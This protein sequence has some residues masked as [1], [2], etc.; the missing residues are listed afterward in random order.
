MPFEV[1]MLSVGV[2]DA[3]V[4]RYILPDTG[5]EV[6]ILIDAGNKQDGPRIVD[7]IKAHTKQQY[8]DLAIC[9]HPDADHIGGFPYIVEH[10]RIEEFWIHDPTRHK[11]N[12]KK[13]LEG[14][15]ADKE[16]EKGL[17]YVVE[18]LHHSY[19]LLKAIDSKQI[20]RRE[21]FAGATF[22][23][24]PLTVVGPTV[25]YYESLLGRFRDADLLWEEELLLEKS[26]KGGDPINLS[27]TNKQIL[28]RSNDQSK[29]NNS[30]V[31]LLFT[32]EDQK[33]LFTSDAGPAA[34]NRAC[35]FTDLSNLDW[36]DVPHHGS[37]Y[38]M[39]SA[40]LAYFNPK[41]AFISCDGSKHYPNPALVAELKALGCEVHAT[42]ATQDLVRRMGTSGGYG[43][44]LSNPL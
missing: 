33:Y 27:L 3:I 30:S 35:Q 24:V 13:L 39:T 38:N 17:K 42:Y 4:I 5:Y 22:A 2:A 12:A 7:Y 8:V 44:Q 29:E 31:I 43:D 34:L 21:P 16:L 26:E 18:N 25:D 40:L 19:N 32:P 37:A 15:Q 9:T 41:I 36:L 14:L 6:V 23:P 20:R 10:L 28:D 11:I 1:H